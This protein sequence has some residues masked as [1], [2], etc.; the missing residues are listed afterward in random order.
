MHLHLH[1]VIIGLTHAP[2]LVG[3]D[4][5]QHGK[6]VAVIAEA[7]ARE[8]GWSKPERDFILQAGMLHDCGV[9]QTR[10]HHDITDGLEWDGVIA[11]CERGGRYLLG[12]PPVGT[13]RAGNICRLRCPK[14]RAW[15]PI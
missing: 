8:M 14:K 13:I 6:R 9:S 12:G 10:E 1:Q 3:V 15:R 4:E 11:H 5:V 7:I 2:D